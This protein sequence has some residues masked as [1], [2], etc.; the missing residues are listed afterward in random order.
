MSGPNRLI[1]KPVWLILLAAAAMAQTQN[2]A[3]LDGAWLGTIDTGL[4]KLRVV[5]HVSET[6]RGLTATMDSLDQGARGIP[7]TSVT[8]SGS[9]LTLVM[10][11]IGG[12]YVGEIAA[13]GGAIRGTW[14]QRGAAVPLVLSRVRKASEVELRRP[15]VPSKP[16]PYREEDVAIENRTAH[17][18]LAG[19]LTLP[20]G[21]GPFPAVLLITGSGPQDRDESI[22]GHKPFLVLADYL[23][24]RGI[25]VLRADDRGTAQSSGN[26]AT[27][28][29]ADFVTDA[30]AGVAYLNSRAEIDHR[31]IGLIGHSEGGAIAAAVA[32]RDR[33]IAWIVL[34]AGAGVPGDALLTEQV[35]LI[36][37]ASGATATQAAAVADRERQILA[38]VKGAKDDAA[39]E[40][41]LR[42][43]LAGQ[44]PR[45]SAQIE[46]VMSPWF[47]YFLELDPARALRQ[48]RCPVLALNGA[49][50]TQVSSKQNLAAIR[51]A[52]Q[53]NH[54]VEVAELPGLNHLFQTARTG[55]PTEY[56]S[57]EETIAPAV[58]E[59]IAGWIQAHVASAP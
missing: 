27:A 20:R 29:T 39:L 8:R 11:Q 3:S 19:T 2:A 31:K 33:Q 12:S 43:E 28:T 48:V 42:A 4:L 51:Q 6:L 21:K 26:F 44:T 1:F 14:S 32:A 45:E 9:K 54:D 52:L 35:R 24:R 18:T 57:I 23:T 10:E 53:D 17:L 36:A 25:A 15:Q 49:R 16:Y 40:R 5:F 38:L 50:D 59:K 13:D 7:V 56:G 47:R 58:L 34:L 41:K 37:Q 30:E 46:A 22:M 55:L